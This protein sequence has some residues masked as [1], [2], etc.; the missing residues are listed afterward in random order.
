MK[1]LARYAETDP[2]RFR[3]ARDILT[4][5]LRSTLPGGF[6]DALVERAGYAGTIISLETSRP[7]LGVVEFDLEVNPVAASKLSDLAPAVQARFDSLAKG[8]FTEAL[9][10][11]FKSRIQTRR[12]DDEQEP[13]RRTASLVDWLAS[14]RGYDDW[15]SRR[16]DLQAVT[17]DDVRALAAALAKPDRVVT[18]S[19]APPP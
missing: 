6:S 1:Q 17:L 16:E 18:G 15:R 7:A 9:L 19:F 12:D 4:E 14:L 3:Q 2:A 10:A 11:R 8:E 13:W 5:F